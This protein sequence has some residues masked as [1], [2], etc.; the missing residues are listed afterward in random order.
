MSC[1]SF[2]DMLAQWYEPL[3]DVEDLISSLLKNYWNTNVDILN[4]EKARE[5]LRGVERTMTVVG[6]DK[7]TDKCEKDRRMGKNTRVR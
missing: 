5:E 2:E 6:E 7:N 4:V 3:Y 1:I